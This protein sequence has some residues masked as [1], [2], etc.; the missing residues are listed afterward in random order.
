MMCIVPVRTENG[1]T[2]MELMVSIVVL[3]PVMAA[4]V[5]LL[6]TG[7]S[8]HALGQSSIDANQD[9]RTAMQIMTTEIA[10]AGSHADVATES[11]SP[12]GGNSVAQSISVDSS[13]GFNVGDYVDVGIKDAGPNDHEVV[14]ITGVTGGDSPTLSGV[15]LRDHTT[16]PVPIRLSALPYTAGVI[17]PDGMSPSSSQDVMTLRFFGHIQG[18]NTDASRNDPT[19]QYVEYSYDPTQSL[20]TRSM[21]PITASTE[22]PALPFIRSVG[23][24]RFTVNTDFL[25]VVTSVNIALTVLSRPSPTSNF[26][27][28]PLSSRISI[29]SAIAGSNFLFEYQQCRGLYPLPPTPAVIQDTWAVLQ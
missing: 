8:Q 15:F 5:S 18:R 29:P 7:A 21:T 28:T 6:S 20:I 9:A 14:E 2:L 24:A 27:Q 26:Q 4:A 17:P 22:N 23:N 11:A 16:T 19:I 13:A 1:F 10:Q 3:I 25:G 12:I